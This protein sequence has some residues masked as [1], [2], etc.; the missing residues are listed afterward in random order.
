MF[1]KEFWKDVIERCVSTFAET[2]IGCVTVGAGFGQTD[3]LGACSIAGVATLVSFLKA[4]VK[5]N[6][7]L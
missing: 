3:W 4:L 7:G 2:F 6:A 5:E 1:T